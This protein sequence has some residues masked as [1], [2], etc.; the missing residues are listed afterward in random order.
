LKHLEIKCD[1]GLTYLWNNL[2]KE[3]FNSSGVMYLKFNG[4][5]SK[6]TKNETGK[7][8]PVFLFKLPK[9]ISLEIE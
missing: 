5:L 7:A 8:V 2:V 3:R 9:L 6:N 4:Q 1:L